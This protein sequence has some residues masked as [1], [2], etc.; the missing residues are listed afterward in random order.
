M[1]ILQNDKRFQ[2]YRYTVE[3]E[4]EQEI[5]DNSKLFFGSDTIYID[6]KRKLKSK[7]L[8]GTI[9]DGF[10]FDLS[11]KEEPEFYIV[12]IELKD[13]D[14]FNHIFP[15]I[16]KFFAFFK[17][18]KSQGELIEKIFSLINDDNFLKKSFKKYLGEKEIYKFIK[19]LIQNSQNILLIIDD[20]KDEL[21]EILDTYTD[22]WGKMVRLLIL[23]KYVNESD[24]IFLLNPDFKD[25]QFTDADSLKRIKTAEPTNYTEED[26]LEGANDQVR[27]IYFRLKEEIL[28][29][30]NDLIFNPQR[31]Y[32]SIIHE[33]NIAFFKIRKKKIRLVIMLPEEEV[34]RRIKNHEIVHLSEGVQK[35]Y[36]GPCCAV[37]IEN[38]KNLGEILSTIQVLINQK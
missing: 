16:T 11:D 31:Y 20:E 23:R 5:V 12:E 2:E 8:G 30:K 4:L 38:D 37:V 29:I 26:H 34:K 17:N 1:I 3:N 15:Q 25:I 35:F 7:S 22:T 19:D 33:R 10:L 6:A 32:V 24:Y 9:P 13:H 18:P 28:K 14:F 21:P 27:E 36:N